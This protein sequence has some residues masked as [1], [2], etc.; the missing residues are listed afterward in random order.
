VIGALILRILPPFRA[1]QFSADSNDGLLRSEP[2]T[3]PAATKD[4]LWALFTAMNAEWHFLPETDQSRLR[5]S[6]DQY[7]GAKSEASPSYA[8]EYESAVELMNHHTDS[9]AGLASLLREKI[10]LAAPIKT[11]K[12]RFHQFVV[13]EFAILYMM[14]GGFLRFG[15]QRYP[16][17]IGGAL[18]NHP[19]R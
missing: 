17:H 4:S 19:Y 14:N 8:A 11:Q 3:L 1:R 16:G 9:G 2:A 10:D 13:R 5:G 18:A 6:F 7:V 12:A 15:I